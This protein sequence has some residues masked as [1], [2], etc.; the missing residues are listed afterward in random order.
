MKLVCKVCGAD[1]VQ[2]EARACG[3]NGAGVLACLSATCYGEGGAAERK[4][5]ALE[6]LIR[7]VVA[8][9][10]KAKS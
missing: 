1:V 4:P 10:R 8:A 3:H 7:A 9:I 6:S 5:N 2:P